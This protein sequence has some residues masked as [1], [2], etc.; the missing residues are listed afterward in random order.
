MSTQCHI[1]AARGKIKLPGNNTVW[2]AGAKM[3]EP[4]KILT[5]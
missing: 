1:P 4:S 2:V 3:S 5:P